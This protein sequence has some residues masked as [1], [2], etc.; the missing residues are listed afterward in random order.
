MCQK[1][2]KDEIKTRLNIQIIELKLELKL[3]KKRKRKNYL[4]NFFKELHINPHKLI[5]CQEK[6][7]LSC[8][9]LQEVKVSEGHS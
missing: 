9:F 4:A 7:K 1:K 8:K 3:V 2:T 5:V 6:K